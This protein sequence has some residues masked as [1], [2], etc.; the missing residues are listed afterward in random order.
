MNIPIPPPELRA[1]YN[2]ERNDQYI[3]QGNK[4]ARQIIEIAKVERPSDEIHSVL[5]FG[6]CAGRVSIHLA[7]MLPSS[8]IWLCDK[9][10]PSIQWV[11]SNLW[12][13]GNLIP[14][15]NEQKYLPFI[16][17]SFDI[18]IA[19]SVL[20]HN[21]DDIAILLELSRVLTRDGVLIVSIHGDSIVDVLKRGDYK[22]LSQQLKDPTL[23]G[24]DKGMRSA[25]KDA[26][27]FGE[28]FMFH[29]HSYVKARWN[30][31]ISVC[32]IIEH[33]LPYQDIVVMRKEK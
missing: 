33:T 5:D 11:R 3:E 23:R 32:D 17:E 1:F 26:G 25:Y 19:L 9:H 21:E 31:I 30:Q 6:G 10:R 12:G 18:I 28:I 15:V 24:W 7:E 13:V 20:T 16:A 27:K 29:S 14:F 2:T 4:Q 8:D 22:H